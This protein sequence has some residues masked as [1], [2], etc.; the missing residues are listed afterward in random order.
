VNYGVFFYNAIAFFTNET[1]YFHVYAVHMYIHMIVHSKNCDVAK[2]CKGF[3]FVWGGAKTTCTVTQVCGRSMARPGSGVFE[4][5][6][7][8][9]PARTWL[10]FYRLLLIFHGAHRF[11][12]DFSFLRVLLR[13]S[14]GT[15][16]YQWTELRYLRSTQY[17]MILKCD[18]YIFTNI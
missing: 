8:M 14:L 9:D 17:N 5:W 16:P 13:E 18:L 11:F 10:L 3:G 1:K 2:F 12:D 15:S 7:R 6:K 4:G